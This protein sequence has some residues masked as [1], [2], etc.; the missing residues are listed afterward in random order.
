MKRTRRFRGGD[1]EDKLEERAQEH[2]RLA[3]GAEDVVRIVQDRVVEGTAEMAVM[4]VMM[5]RSPA[6]RPVFRSRLI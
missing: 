1:D 4:K 5:K 6:I 2:A 3:A